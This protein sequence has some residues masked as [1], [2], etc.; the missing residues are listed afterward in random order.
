MVEFPLQKVITAAV[1][2]MSNVRHHKFVNSTNSGHIM[3]TRK[4]FVCKQLLQR[5]NRIH[6]YELNDIVFDG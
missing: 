6:T 5:A 3:G 2:S 1:K 4:T